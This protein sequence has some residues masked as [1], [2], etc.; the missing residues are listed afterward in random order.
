MDG[1]DDH[2][3]CLRS[4]SALRISSGV[5]ED[6]RKN[7]KIVRPLLSSYLNSIEDADLCGD[8]DRLS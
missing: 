2:D 4:L 6:S 7:Q 5:H 1:A 8:L 3:D